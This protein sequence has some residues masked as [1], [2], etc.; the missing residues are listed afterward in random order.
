LVEEGEKE[1]EALGSI[2]KA[3]KGKGLR[4]SWTQ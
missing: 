3:E 4:K 1:I 2:M